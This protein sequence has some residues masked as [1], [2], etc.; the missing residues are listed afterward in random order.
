MA[1]TRALA[2]VA[3]L[4]TAALFFMSAR[5]QQCGTQAGGALCPDCLCC[6][7]WGYCGS[8][9]DYC[10][11][12]CQSQCFGSGCGGGGGTPATPPSGPVSEIISESLFN[13]MLLHRNDVACPAIGFY[14]YDAFIAAANAFPGFGTTGGADTQKR[15]LA[16]FLAQTSHETTGGWDTA[17]DGPYTWGYCFKEEVGGV[18]GPDYCQPSPRGRAPTAR[19]TTAAGPSSSPGTTTTGP[20]GRP[21]ARTFWA[22]QVWLPPT[23]LSPSRRRSGTG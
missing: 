11:D 18:W 6:S 17:P 8:T 19:S 9:P 5:A 14:T 16:A 7:Q 22:N 1:M 20:P 3:M 12:G 2:M 15:E 13:E 21:S 10:T 23:P 4:A